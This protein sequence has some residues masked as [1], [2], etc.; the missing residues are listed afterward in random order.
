[1]VL[2]ATH[3]MEQNDVRAHMNYGDIPFPLQHPKFIVRDSISETK[4]Y[5]S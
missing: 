2:C 1:M 4:Y 3:T 5:H